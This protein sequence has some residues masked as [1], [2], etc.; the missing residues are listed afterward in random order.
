MGLNY[1]SESNL[2]SKLILVAVFGVPILIVLVALAK[3]AGLADATA[4]NNAQLARHI[5]AGHGFVTS[6]LQPL[7]VT[8]TGAGQ[9]PPDVVSPPVQPALLA[10]TFCLTGAKAKVV[11]A[12]GLGLWLLTVWLVFLVARYW[13]NWRVAGLA[14]L[15]YVCTLTGL[16]TAAAGLPQPIMALLVLGAMAAVFPKASSV[17]EGNFSLALWQ[18]AV[19]GLLCGLATLTDYR[20]VP[21]ALVLSVFLFLTQTRRAAMLALFVGGVLLVLA[22]WGVRNLMVSGRLFGL[23]WY[24]ALENT[25][26][27]PGATIWQLTNVPKHPF[28]SLLVHPADLA[29]KLVFGFIQYQRAGLGLLGPVVVFLGAVALFGAP[30]KSSRRRLAGLA[31]SGVVLTVLLSCLT[32]P[33]GRLLLAWAPVLGCVAA[34]QLVAWVQG[35]VNGFSTENKRFR[36]KTWVL[37]GLTYLGVV[38]VLVGPAA[39]QFSNTNFGRRLD[40][41]SL[42]AIKQRIPSSGVVM[43]DAPAFVAWYLDRPALLLCQREGDLAELEKQAGKIAGGYFSP[44]LGQLPPWEQGDWWVWAAS[45]RGVYR[46]LEV[47]ANSPLPGLLRVPQNVT[48]Q[49]AGELELDRLEAVQKSSSAA[50]PVESR[51]QLAYE[52]LRLGRLREA[53][54]TFQEINRLDK[55]NIDALVGLWETTA[56]LSQSDGTLQLAK[57]A[58]QADPRDP[59]TKP[60]LE[61]LAM[62]FDRVLTQRPGDPWLLMNLIKCRSRLGQWKKVET[63]SAQLSQTLPATFPARL[64]LADIHLKQN[65]LAKAATECEQLLQEHPD[66]PAAHELAGRLCLAQ[67]KPE[68]ALKEFDTTVRL[69]PQWITVYVQAGLVCQRLQRDDAAVKYLETALKLVPNSINL[70]MTLADVYATQGKTAEALGLYREILAADAKQPT[71]LNNL[72]VLLAKTGQTTEALPLVRQAVSLVPQNPH[73]RDTA[74]WIAFLTGNQNEALLHLLEAVRIAPQ[75]GLAHFHLGKVLLSQGQKTEARQAFKRALECGLPAAEQQEAQTATAGL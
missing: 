21:L 53:Q 51:T 26:R 39:L 58:N 1:R 71:V 34:A 16:L 69:R 15:F 30:A 35:N 14:A 74:G 2:R 31:F 18:P 70:K 17:T 7:A 27:F 75:L 67:D 5:A 8:L 6:A 59:R 49:L 12:V 37:R 62:L 60:M 50:L 68:D 47:V 48:A 28:L 55:Y 23:Y 33:D 46:G 22:P 25:G 57:L 20:L 64:L 66:L 45:S 54:Q 29:R 24:G 42:T 56:Q 11:A 52:Y 38:A 61:D 73:F 63:Y 40:P 43:T 41:A 3:F 72:A 13:W 10:A 36:L 4:L 44:A 65:E 19:A 32:R 9:T